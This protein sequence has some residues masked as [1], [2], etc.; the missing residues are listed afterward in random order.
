MELIY[1]TAMHIHVLATLNALILTAFHYTKYVMGKQTVYIV[2][3]R[4]IAQV[5]WFVQICSNA[6]Q[7]GAFIQ[8]KYVTDKCNVA[9][10]QMTN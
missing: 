2:K 9:L 4:I 1:H 5:H 7:V 6:D 10:N 8:A 3:T